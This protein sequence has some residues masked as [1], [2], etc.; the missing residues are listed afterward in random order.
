MITT[1]QTEMLAIA[2][3]ATTSP[4]HL[5]QPIEATG[6]EFTPHL[7]KAV[8]LRHGYTLAH[9]NDLTVRAVRTQRFNRQVDFTDRLELAWSAIAEF[10]YA[11][12][13]PPTGA[14]LIRA[15]W[16]AIGDDTDRTHRSHGWSTHD[17]YAGLTGRF[18]QYW[19]GS[20]HHTHSPEEPVVERVALAQIWPR[21]SATHRQLL[22][23][24]AVHDDYGRAAEALDK[25]RKTFTTQL[26]EARR[27]F[28]TLWHHGEQ[29][30][31]PWGTDRRTS[32]N[33][34]DRHA[35]T[36]VIR[37]RE[38]RRHHR[39]GAGQ[40]LPTD[41]VHPPTGRVTRRLRRSAATTTASRGHR[42]PERADRR[43]TPTQTPSSKAHLN[44]RYT[45]CPANRATSHGQLAAVPRVPFQSRRR[46]NS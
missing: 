5:D 22:L 39:G 23:A 3:E 46:S 24:M 17:R 34:T 41:E 14:D 6:P 7:A 21:L 43:G 45:L 2:A 8:P 44:R 37:L 31:R 40:P 9:L 18:Q 26:S 30:S 11:A 10:L 1:A 28:L 32:R 13:E 33:S 29:P 4:P 27:A 42:P 35:R 36:Y 16:A 15:A 25:S 38:R 12:D 20:G 19:V